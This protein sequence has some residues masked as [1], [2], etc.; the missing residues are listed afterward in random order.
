MGLA[1]TH[2]H[3]TPNCLN[4]PLCRSGRF[5][6]FKKQALKPYPSVGQKYLGPSRD[7]HA[8][9]ALVIA[10]KQDCYLTPNA[11]RPRL[12][13]RI[14]F[15]NSPCLK[16]PLRLGLAEYLLPTRDLHACIAL[17]TVPMPF[18]ETGQDGVLW[19]HLHF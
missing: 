9:I 16:T 10:C 4:V 19:A 13:K 12:E 3:E 18:I 14:I 8:C 5:F 2:I 7:V 6:G 1:T 15:L 17:A 11:Q